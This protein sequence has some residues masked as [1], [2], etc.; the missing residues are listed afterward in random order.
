[1]S[2]YFYNLFSKATLDKLSDRQLTLF[3]ILSLA[4]INIFVFWNHYIGQAIFPWDFLG[5]Y[6]A[7]PFSWYRD[8]SWLSPPFWNNY[9]NYGFPW[10]LALQSSSYYLPIQLIELL[11]IPYTYNTAAR[12]QTL[13]ILF[14]SI[15]CFFLC[16]QQGVSFLASLFSALVFHFSIGFYGNA[17][18]IDIVRAYAFTPWVFFLLSSSFLSNLRCASIAAVV[19]SSFVVASY[20]GAIVALTFIFPIYVVYSIVFVNRQLS[21]RYYFLLLIFTLVTSICLIAI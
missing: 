10:H 1:M 13:H 14:G 15:G 9:G 6:H 21:S 18:H 3:S 8:G 2:P 7:M 17:Q 19:V 11:D 4:L 12:L 20:P 16:R 5:G